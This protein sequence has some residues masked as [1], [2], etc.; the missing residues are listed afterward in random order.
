MDFRYLKCT[1]KYGITFVR[2]KSDFSVVV[3]IDA[4]YAR[5]LDDKRSTTC[6]MFTLAGGPIC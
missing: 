2:Q 5:D 6:Y 1:I 3:Y 4:D